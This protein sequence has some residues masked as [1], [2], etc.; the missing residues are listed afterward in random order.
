VAVGAQDVGQHEGIAR[1]GL[2][3]RGAV[4]RAAGLDDVR[5]D[6]DHRVA[7]PDQ[8]I[9]DQARG[10]L[11]GDRQ[12]G[13][14]R[15]AREPGQ[16]FGEAG[17]VVPGADAGDD[18]AGAVNDAGGVAG[19]APIQTRVELHGLTSSACGRLARVGRSSGSLTDRR[20]G[21][22]A[23]AR[24]PV[25]R[26]GLP[27]PAVRLVSR[28]PSSGERGRPSRQGLG[29]PDTTPLRGSA[30]DSPKVHQ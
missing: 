18:P 15:D 19:A 12:R 27:A 8:G 7:G 4:A 29:P 26:R 22:Q 21:R 11:D 13:R 9:D 10:P 24:H 1:I 16:Q 3:A 28:G 5:M 30:P 20:S 17:T 23:L 25:V 6:R 14:R 2:A